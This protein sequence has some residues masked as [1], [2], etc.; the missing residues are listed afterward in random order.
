MANDRTLEYILSLKDEASAVWRRFSSETQK[1][2]NEI[3]SSIKNIGSAIAA[4]FT[5]DA[6]M[7]FMEEA[8]AAQAEV[9]RLEQ[10]LKQLGLAHDGVTE[11]MLEYSDALKAKTAF[12]DDDITHLQGTILAMTG[13]LDAVKKLTPAVLDLARATGTNIDAAAKMF[14]KSVEGSEGL[15]R[16]GIT[17]GDTADETERFNKV[18][19]AINAKYGGQAAAWADTDAGKMEKLKMSFD[20]LGKIIGKVFNEILTP[21]LPGIIKLFEWLGDVVQ[22][23]VSGIKAA[24]ATV[25]TVVLSFL[26]VIEKGLNMLGISQSKTMQGLQVSAAKLMMQYGDDVVQA[27]SGT[28]K[29]ATTASVAVKKLDEAVST[30][31]VHVGVKDKLS[32]LKKEL[33]NLT[34]G[35]EAWGKKM[36]EI[37]RIEEQFKIA[38]ENAM[39]KAKGFADI[40]IAD[41]KFSVKLSQDMGA[42]DEDIEG[43]SSYVKKSILKSAGNGPSF[44]DFMDTGKGVGNIQMDATFKLTPVIDPQK[45]AEYSA[46]VDAQVT[47]LGEV[48]ARK[49][50]DSFKT[51]KDRELGIVNEWEKN[52]VKMA[53]DSQSLI[54][55]IQKIAADDRMNIELE[56][57]KKAFE[58]AAKIATRGIGI[59]NKFNQQASQKEIQDLEKKKTKE[60][61]AIDAERAA[62]E[63]KYSNLM[64][65]ES[66]T[67]AQKSA[68]KKK[69]E[70]EDAAIL[71]RRTAIEDAY[72]K[73]IA[74]EKTEAFEAEKTASIIEAIIN[75]AV[76][77]TSA[78]PNFVLAAVVGAMGAAEVAL[79]AS[80]PTPTFH[81]GGSGYFN[82]PAS[83]EAMVK[84]RGGETIDVYTPEQR[85]ER[86]TNSNSV[87]IVQN[88]N[89]P[90]TDVVAVK[91]AVQA[92]LR[93]TGLTVDKYFVNNIGKAVL[94]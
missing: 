61:S 65:N 7:G 28:E 15:K 84:I 35:T 83:S 26:A 85:D 66:L 24:F 81:A 2:S 14:S 48:E 33:D 31:A 54:T 6:I 72:N 77:V 88:F 78:L 38:T 29:A 52:A 5:V 64:E 18:Y 50:Y 51:E 87:T 58:G 3:S 73:K 22:A 46:Q 80:Q 19:D 12:D 27:F 11:S 44:A 8:A 16:L 71:V 70:E 60:L 25:Y 4:A 82:A 20:D 89:S 34:P 36:L 68:L 79:I 57:Q 75:T 53:G 74:A 69:A 56:A 76:G 21:A 39:R 67:D 1:D 55:D 62:I 17:I 59:I 90:F 91:R 63:K 10:T 93:L 43:L 42:I 23:T 32:L 86:Q 41:I 92:G 37:I 94:T 47:I 45:M 40:G 9:V 49:H 30:E 13:N